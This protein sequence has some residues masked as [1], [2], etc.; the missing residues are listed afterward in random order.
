M[1]FLRARLSLAAFA[2]L[3]ALV[4]NPLPAPV[5]AAAASQHYSLS[6]D[7][8]R[9]TCLEVADSN[10]VFGPNYY[11]GH[12][13]PSLLF[14][15]NQP[16][17]GGKSQW[18]M[19]LPKDPPPV[20]KANGSRSWNFQ[21]HP[22]FWFGMALCDTQSAPNPI[23]NHV[24]KPNS[25]SNITSDAQI[26]R[27]AGTAFLELQFY[28]PGGVL[29]PPGNSCDAHKWCVAFVIWSL[30]M[31]YPSGKALNDTCANSIGVESPNFAFLTLNGKP[32]APAN[33]VN[34]TLATY[35]PDAAR[36][37]FMNSGDKTLTSIHDTEHGLSIEVKDLTTGQKGSMVASAANS[38]GQVKFA[39]NPSTECTNI[40][41]DFH[42][43]YATSSEHT[44]VPWAAHSY[45]VAF[46]DEIG[47]F[48]FCPNVKNASITG[49]T[50]VCASAS[51]TDPAGPDADDTFCFT[52]GMSSLVRIGG[53]TNTDGDFDGRRGVVLGSLHAGGDRLVS[54]PRRHRP[55]LDQFLA[56]PQ[57][58]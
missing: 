4:G 6:C 25:D 44:R 45:N 9:A 39:A 17:S 36:D 41:Y 3:F 53:C 33:A 1:R 46:S 13:E 37:L 54:K 42:A 11:V 2:G 32:Q 14:Y 40:P 12:D 5:A 58:S 26:A 22:A 10:E 28:P 18:L 50:G 7:E 15:S 20:P 35:T 8:G 43:M 38:F 56:Q 57:F 21:L 49:A 24:C 27:H 16:G 29:W 31:D 47:H 19:T 51:A 23:D 30:A 34:A 55:D 52:P 48:E